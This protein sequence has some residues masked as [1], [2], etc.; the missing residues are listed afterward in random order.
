LLPQTPS[1]SKHTLGFER[2]LGYALCTAPPP[3]Q[4]EPFFSLSPS[5]TPEPLGCGLVA[6]YRR[7]RPAA[8]HLR[9]GFSPRR[10]FS[11]DTMPPMSCQVFP[12]KN[13]LFF[14]F[15]LRRLFAA[16]ILNLIIF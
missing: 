13:Y 6:K 8:P 9:G 10:K 5:L 2:T 3:I 12:E 4:A 7:G 1:Y 11:E 16:Q 14:F 15:F